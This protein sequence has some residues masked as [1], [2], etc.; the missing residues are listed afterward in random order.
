MSIT[1]EIVGLLKEY[2]KVHPEQL[3]SLEGMTVEA[4]L[5][6]LGMPR[7]LVAFVMVNGR[8]KPKSY[9]LAPDDNVKLIPFVGGG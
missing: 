5:Q 9:T 1:L 4:L 2:V 6:A 3:E 7:E 8:Q